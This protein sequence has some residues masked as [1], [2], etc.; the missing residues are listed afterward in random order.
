MTPF[1]DLFRI[2]DGF[3]SIGFRWQLKPR[4]FVNRPLRNDKRGEGMLLNL[5]EW[6]LC[7]SGCG[8]WNSPNSFSNSHGGPVLSASASSFA[9]VSQIVI[10]FQKSV[11]PEA[12]VFFLQSPG[13]E[14]DRGELVIISRRDL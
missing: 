9:A 4:S 1:S 10:P 3:S 14:K 12:F 7:F 13:D 2:I 11:C 6:L 5:I 8:Q